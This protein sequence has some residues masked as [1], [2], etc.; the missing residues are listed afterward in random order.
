MSKFLKIFILCATSGFIFLSD[1][2][3]LAE[4]DKG[5]RSSLNSAVQKYR[6]SAL[7]KINLEKKANSKIL[8]RETTEE[9]ILYFSGGFVRFET[10]KPD[11]A[12]VVFDGT[13]LWNVQLPSAD[14]GGDTIVTKAHIDKQ[15][16][17]QVIVTELL[18]KESLFTHFNLDSSKIEGTELT[19][20][21]T[22]KQ[23]DWNLLKIKL[24]V[25]SKE[26]LV[27]QI[28]YWDD[29]DNHTHLI[30]KKQE[31]LTEKKPTLFQYKPPKGVKV[32]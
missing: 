25:S 10:Q 5:H 11:P 28:E 14:F 18:S 16:R 4:I 26:N 29:L 30:F 21:A 19:V 15:N 23:K 32:N 6:R 3:A 31:F 20:E 7:V 12:L 8:K 24:H 1:V 2:F 17:Q 9:G 27:T 22:P 13:F